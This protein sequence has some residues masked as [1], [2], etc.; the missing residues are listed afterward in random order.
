MQGNGTP[1][2]E[3]LYDKDARTG[4]FFYVLRHSHENVS[5]ALFPWSNSLLIFIMGI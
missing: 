4:V 2:K 3:S 1:A 5:L